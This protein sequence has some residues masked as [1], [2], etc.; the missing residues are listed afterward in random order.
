MPRSSPPRSTAVADE[1]DVTYE[2]EMPFDSKNAKINLIGRDDEVEVLISDIPVPKGYGDMGGS[3]KSRIKRHAVARW[4]VEDAARVI[5]EYDWATSSHV[6]RQ[7]HRYLSDV[8]FSCDREEL[9]DAVIAAK[10]FLTR[11]EEGVLEHARKF[12]STLQETP[13]NALESK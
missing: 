9:D 3:D 7:R 12:D 2:I 5:E 13:S 10:Q 11:L 6:S 4:V 8:Y 1:I